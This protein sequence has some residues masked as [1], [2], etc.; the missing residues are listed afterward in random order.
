MDGDTQL[1]QV[2]EEFEQVLKK[3]ID[4]L[5]NSA[6]PQDRRKTAPLTETEPVVHDL[7]VDKPA[8][9]SPVNKHAQVP[10]GFGPP[11]ENHI[12][13]SG[14]GQDVNK[15]TVNTISRNVPMFQEV[16]PRGKEWEDPL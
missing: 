4:D 13:K 1:P 6:L 10:N 3:T 9:S 8:V 5:E 16:P 14:H 2:R 7:E 15:D 12:A 11:R